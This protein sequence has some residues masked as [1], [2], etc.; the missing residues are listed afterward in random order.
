MET[1]LFVKII[2]VQALFFN[3]EFQLHVLRV[4]YAQINHVDQIIHHVQNIQLVL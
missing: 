2:L 1:K 4:Y 3:A